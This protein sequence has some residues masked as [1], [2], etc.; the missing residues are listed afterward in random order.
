MENKIS[1]NEMFLDVFY[2]QGPSKEKA[3]ALEIK[4]AA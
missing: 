4:I 3:Q 1:K 2:I